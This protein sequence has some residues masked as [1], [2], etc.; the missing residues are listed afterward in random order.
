V[1]HCPADADPVP[2]RITNN[3]VSMGESARVSYDFYSLHWQP[4]LGPMLARLRGQAPLAW[5]MGVSEV[6]SG[7][8]NH[9]TGGGNVVYAD[10]H[11]AWLAVREWNAPDWPA[12][13]SEFYPTA[14]VA[15]VSSFP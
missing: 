2:R 9:G 11:A 13:A 12:P 1:F 6:P 4:E 7:L 10:G 14:A 5:D 8:Q 3:Y 15:A